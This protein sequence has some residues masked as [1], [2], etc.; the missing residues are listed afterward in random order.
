MQSDRYWLHVCEAARLVDG[1]DGVRFELPRPGREPLAA[2]VVRA[3]G[4]VGAFLNRCAHVPIELDWM[5]GRF[6][7]ESGRFVVCATHGALY[8]AGSGA[9]MGGPCRGAP[10]VAL[11]VREVDGRI[12]VAIEP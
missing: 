11:P 9:C 1:G 10:L 5:P 4:V 6:L 3:G 8:H 7:D 12:E 2:F